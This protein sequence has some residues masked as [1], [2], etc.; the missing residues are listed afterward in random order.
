M[1]KQIMARMV[2]AHPHPTAYPDVPPHPDR[3]DQG[4]IGMRL[5]IWRQLLQIDK[6]ARHAAMQALAIFLTVTFT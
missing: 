4:E 2:K 6:Y 5:E 3:M 1:L